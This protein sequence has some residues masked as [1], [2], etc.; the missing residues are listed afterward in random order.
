MFKFIKSPSFLFHYCLY[1]IR[2]WA[3]QIMKGLGIEQNML[4]SYMKNAALSNVAQSSR[5]LFF[6]HLNESTSERGYFHV[7]QMYGSGTGVLLKMNHNFF[8]LTAKHVINNNTHGNFQNESP[9]WITSKS[10]K[11]WES[12]HDFLLPA[13]IWN[14]GELVKLD[15]KYVDTDDICLVE[16]FRPFPLHMPDHFIDIKDASCVLSENE[17]FEGQFLLVT[18]YPFKTN[19]FDFTQISDEVTHTTKL[20]RHTIHGVYI[21][22]EDDIGFISFEFTDGDIQHKDVNGMSGGVIYNIQPEVNQIK[23]AGIAISAGD[24][25]CRFFPAYAFIDAILRYK[26]SSSI[27]VD[28]NADRVFDPEVM[29]EIFKDYMDKFGFDS[30]KN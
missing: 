9:F 13:R 17:L 11:I 23:L 12:L 22:E 3:Y 24:N 16:L 28:P 8:L 21:K 10:K 1:K 19:N 29:M 15:S 14:I 18:G 6:N 26:E 20:Q 2:F 4:S 5:R 27:T 7:D 30:Q 25:I